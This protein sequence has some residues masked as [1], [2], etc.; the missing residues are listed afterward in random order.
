MCL[1]VRRDHSEG[2]GKAACA[3]VYL[4]MSFFD[5][6][7]SPFPISLFLLYLGYSLKMNYNYCLVF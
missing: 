6:L 2:C 1:C 7:L 3:A 4:D 5:T